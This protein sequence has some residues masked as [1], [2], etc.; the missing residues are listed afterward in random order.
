[1]RARARAWPRWRTM[2][3]G[4]LPSCR[5][6]GR[7]RARLQGAPLMGGWRLWSALV[8]GAGDVVDT[9]VC[10]HVQGPALVGVSERQG[11]RGSD[12]RGALLPARP[13]PSRPPAARA[14]AGRRRKAGRSR[15]SATLLHPRRTARHLASKRD[16]PLLAGLIHTQTHTHLH[17]PAG[18]T[19]PAPRRAE[20]KGRN[21]HDLPKPW[22]GCAGAGSCPRSTRR[23]TSRG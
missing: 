22:P 3:E 15:W 10:S 19:L 1:M 23:R 7:A 20:D 18:A 21:S 14:V 17:T 11:G 13:P 12:G 5:Q 9:W 4:K 16:L 6:P 2:T 8:N